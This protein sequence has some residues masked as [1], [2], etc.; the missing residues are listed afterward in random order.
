M[1]RQKTRRNGKGRIERAG[2]RERKKI[3]RIKKG[4]RTTRG[5][6]RSLYE[7]YTCKLYSNIQ[8]P[9]NTFL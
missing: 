7:V 3:E 6:E 1:E 2:E 4:G 5:G 8:L 9:S